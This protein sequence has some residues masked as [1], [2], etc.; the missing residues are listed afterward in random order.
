VSIKVNDIV[1]EQ[2]RNIISGLFLVSFWL[3]SSSGYY[4]A[5]NIQEPMKVLTAF[6]MLKEGYQNN[7]HDIENFCGF[8]VKLPWGFHSVHFSVTPPFRQTNSGGQNVF[9]GEVLIGPVPF[10]S[11]NFSMYNFFV[12]SSTDKK[13][14]GIGMDLK[15][16][17]NLNVPWNTSIEAVWGELKPWLMTNGPASSSSGGKESGRRN[18]PSNASSM[19]RRNVR[20]VRIRGQTQN[21][22]AWYL[23]EYNT[24]PLCGGPARWCPGLTATSQRGRAI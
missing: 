12:V 4:E 19:I 7:C 21:S 3:I 16:V 2:R 11:Y 14:I 13:F 18:S 10:T 15:S 23:R 17:V 20:L 22:E 6:L 8:D 5:L 9:I 1:K 24:L